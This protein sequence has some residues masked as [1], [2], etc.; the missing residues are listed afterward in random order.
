MVNFKVYDV[1][2]WT[3]NNC[4]HITNNISR[5]KGNQTMKLGQLIEYNMRYS[6]LE[7]S[8]TKCDGEATS[9]PFHRKSKLS[10]LKCYK[11]CFYCISNS[12]SAKIY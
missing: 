9:R 7:K 2:D 3:T 1:T 5:T 6:F 4:K 10:A 12:R 11:V 8:Y